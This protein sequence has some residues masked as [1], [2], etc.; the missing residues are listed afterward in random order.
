MSS[1]TQHSFK[2]WQ[3]GGRAYNS[4][5]VGATL[6]IMKKVQKEIKRMEELDIIEPTDELTEWCSQ[7][8]KDVLT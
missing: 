4:S 2:A 7:K 5:E 3:T 6:P 1:S 8:G